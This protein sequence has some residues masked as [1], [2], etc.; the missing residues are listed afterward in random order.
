MANQLLS[1]I[2][3]KIEKI[4]IVPEG[5]YHQDEAAKYDGIRDV[6]P[7]D[8]V[9]ELRI[10]RPDYQISVSQA[11]SGIITRSGANRSGSKNLRESVRE[12]TQYIRFGVIED[13]YRSP[14]LVSPKVD[15]GQVLRRWLTELQRLS[16]GG[17]QLS[18]GRWAQDSLVVLTSPEEGPNILLQPLYSK[19]LTDFLLPLYLTQENSLSPSFYVQSINLAL[20]GGN[21]LCGDQEVFIGADVLEENTWIRVEHCLYDLAKE[22]EQTTRSEPGLSTFPPDEYDPNLP[23]DG[24]FLEQEA[25]F[26]RPQDITLSAFQEELK[27]RFLQDDVFL[28]CKASVE[29]DI[30]QILGIDTIHFI[31]FDTPRPKFN[32]GYG[33]NSSQPL[34]HLDLFM[35]LTGY[36]NESGKEVILIGCPIKSQQIRNG[37]LESSVF[38]FISGSDEAKEGDLADL[39]EGIHQQFEATPMLKEKYDLIRIPLL[40]H[41]REIFSWNNAIVEVYE[42]VFN[43]YLPTF[44]LDNCDNVLN[45]LFRLH[46]EEVA[47]ICIR[48]NLTP[49]FIGPGQF[50][51]DMA[52]RKGSLNCATKVLQR[53]S[54]RPFINP[55]AEQSGI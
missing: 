35:T 22:M 2:Y 33:S 32:C 11:H 47:K 36:Q 52:D 26:G 15:L 13:V 46:E 8:K 55:Q 31:G 49:H 44:R 6:F 23:R 10:E 21:M 20:P 19:N 25:Y 39:M 38:S 1:S 54:Y 24:R 53:S 40:F 41:D 5:I 14:H 45:E 12:L 7:G 30:T 18:H 34:F 28:Q 16:Q 17:D 50:M 9:I 42:S 48:C 27:R 4:L 43:I 37:L 3:G 29:E 51:R